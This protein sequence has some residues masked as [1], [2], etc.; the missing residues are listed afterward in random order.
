M[1]NLNKYLLPLR[2]RIYDKQSPTIPKTAYHVIC[3][4]I[5]L[6]QVYVRR[7]QLFS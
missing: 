4:H 1:R 2:C 3:F 5:R 6:I 7:V